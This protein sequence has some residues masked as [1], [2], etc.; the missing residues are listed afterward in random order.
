MYVQGLWSFHSCF[1]FSHAVNLLLA[2]V[3]A[4]H[5]ASTYQTLITLH[6]MP[7]WCAWS[8]TCL[9][10]AFPSAT[11]VSTEFPWEAAH[12]R[13]TELSLGSIATGEQRGLTEWGSS[14]PW[15]CLKSVNNMSQAKQW[16][17]RNWLKFASPSS[18]ACFNVS[19]KS[20]LENV[21]WS[22][23]F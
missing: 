15:S 2:H 4:G 18:I 23:C 21:S 16:K 1:L 8:C 17:T 10:H 13:M 6:D 19:G 7:S 20:H 3:D 9:D 22:L 11:E 14:R 12:I 5:V